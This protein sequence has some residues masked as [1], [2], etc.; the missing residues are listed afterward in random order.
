MILWFRFRF[1]PRKVWK[2][3]PEEGRVID[4]NEMHYFEIDPELQPALKKKW[5]EAKE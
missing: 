3:T 5:P 4:S 2:I 1:K